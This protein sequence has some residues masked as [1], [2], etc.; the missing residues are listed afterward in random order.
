MS[1]LQLCLCS[2]RARCRRKAPLTRSEKKMLAENAAIHPAVLLKRLAAQQTWVC[3]PRKNLP[4]ATALEDRFC[5]SFPLRMPA[6][7]PLK[8]G[9]FAAR[10]S[11]ELTFASSTCKGHTY[12]RYFFACCQRFFTSI[13]ATLPWYFPREFACLCLKSIQN[14]QKR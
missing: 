1:I 13:G 6:P 11:A 3:W 2:A 10:L 7:Q 8:T 4:H 14:G 9:Q 12:R 5:R